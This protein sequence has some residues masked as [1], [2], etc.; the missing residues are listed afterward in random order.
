MTATISGVYSDGKVEL[1]ETP[2]G[3]RE[4]RVQ[5]ILSEIE[6]AP[7]APRLLQYGKYAHGRMATEEDFLSAEWRGE[8]ETGDE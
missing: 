1:L 3:L 6:E 2:S 7:A 8:A 5:V 4:G